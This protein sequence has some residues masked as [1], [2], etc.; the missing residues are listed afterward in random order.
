MKIIIKRKCGRGI[1]R[2]K[3]ETK[4]EQKQLADAIRRG[5][6]IKTKDK[7]GETKNER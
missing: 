7:E 2:I 6:G 4:A 3:A 1:L 5:L